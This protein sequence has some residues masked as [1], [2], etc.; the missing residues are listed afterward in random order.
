MSGRFSTNGG[1]LRLTS[2]AEPKNNVQT[3][4]AVRQVRETQSG[5]L[6]PWA[7]FGR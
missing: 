7:R 6:R 4:E 3:A 2:R 1:T 5:L